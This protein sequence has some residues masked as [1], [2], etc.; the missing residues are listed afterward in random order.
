LGA[1]G[2]E[3]RSADNND[4]SPVVNWANEEWTKMDKNGDGVIQPE[5]FDDSLKK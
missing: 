3:K 5:E 1:F 4:S 2:K